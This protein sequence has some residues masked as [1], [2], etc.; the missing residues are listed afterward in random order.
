MRRLIDTT[1][2]TCGCEVCGAGETELRTLGERSGRF[3]QRQHDYAWRHRDVQC[4]RCGFVFNALR[5]AAGF[6]RDYY[7]DCWPIASSS[8]TIEPDYSLGTR[9]ELLSRWLKPGAKLYEIG[10]K[11][12]EFHAALHAAGFNV[13]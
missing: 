8:V 10:D 2:T 6:L 1:W 9:L 12:G 7:A 11:L 3:A 13:V 4:G 5:P